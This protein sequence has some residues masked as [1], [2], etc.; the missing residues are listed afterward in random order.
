MLG[1]L[2]KLNGMT[3]TVMVVAI[4]HAELL[5]MSVQMYQGP[6]LV[7]QKAVTAGDVKILMVMDGLTKEI[8]SYTNHHSGVMKTAMALEIIQMVMKEM[9]VQMNVANHSSID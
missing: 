8:N 3:V 5:Q 1:L 7:Q 9:H 6:L 2:T 4:I